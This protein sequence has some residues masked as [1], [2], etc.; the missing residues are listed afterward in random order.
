MELIKYGYVIWVYFKLHEIRSREVNYP[1]ADDEISIL[2]FP[3][4]FCCFDWVLIVLV[5]EQQ[6]VIYPLARSLGSLNQP[7]SDSQRALLLCCFGVTAIIALAIFQPA[8][9]KIIKA[10]N[11]DRGAI[12]QK[13][14]MRVNEWYSILG[15]Q[16]GDAPAVSVRAAAQKR[17]RE[18]FLAGTPQPLC[19]TALPLDW[20]RIYSNLWDAV[21]CKFSTKICATASSLVKN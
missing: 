19:L 17:G 3:W 8:D 5:Q 6:K 21:C 15:R 14:A 20:P 10:Y 4:P 18:R 13:C 16:R 9:V 1:S 12:F 11:F 7:S 2:H